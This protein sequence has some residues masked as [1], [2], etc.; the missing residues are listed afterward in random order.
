[1]LFQSWNDKPDWSL[2]DSE[3]FTFTGFIRMYFEDKSKLGFR[4]EGRGA[5]LAFKKEV[6]YSAALPGYGGEKAVDGDPGTLW[7]SGADPV[8]W[9]EI[10]LGAAYAIQSIQPLISQYPAGMTVHR[11]RGRGE[12][13][14]D[15]YVTLHTFE[16]VTS[17][18][19]L[20]IYSPEAPL[21]KMRFI[22]IETLTS[23]SWVAWR[24]IVVIDAG[25][26]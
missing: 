22:R 3:A 21:P 25:A 10:D 2:P 6:R 17:E 1:V 24:E 9:I 26:P 14:S 15:P 8:Q 7:N 23:P 19:S 4:K 20:L 18:D 5:N 11:V 13:P 16:G 12:N